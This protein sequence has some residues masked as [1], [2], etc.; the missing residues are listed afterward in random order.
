MNQQKDTGI[1]QEVGEVGMALLDTGRLAAAVCIGVLRLAFLA[2][3]EN[4]FCPGPGL[5]IPCHR[6]YDRN[7]EGGRCVTCHFMSKDRELQ[8]FALMF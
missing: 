5:G 6:P 3:P 8:Y 1:L 2:N 4:I 7:R